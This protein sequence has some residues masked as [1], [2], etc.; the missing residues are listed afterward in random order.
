MVNDA[1]NFRLPNIP[2]IF[3]LICDLSASINPDNAA[4]AVFPAKGRHIPV[5]A[6]AT[7]ATIFGHHLFHILAERSD[8][9]KWSLVSSGLQYFAE[10]FKKL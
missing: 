9:A 3:A 4:N 6:S 1:V 8:V 2:G 7:A 10:R 5:S